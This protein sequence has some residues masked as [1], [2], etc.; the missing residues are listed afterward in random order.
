MFLLD[1]YGALDVLV[2]NFSVEWF[3]P[4]L[5]LLFRLIKTKTSRQLITGQTKWRPSSRCTYFPGLTMSHHRAI[6][7]KWTSSDFSWT[8]GG[9][10]TL[11]CTSSRISSGTFFSSLFISFL[12][13]CLLIFLFFFFLLSEVGEKCLILWRILLSMRLVNPSCT[14][15][16]CASVN[17][18]TTPT[19][20]NTL[21]K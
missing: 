5:S 1:F 13:L 10:Q 17:C 21:R 16:A 9:M 15:P 8:A 3:I 6:C 18:W 7:S 4:N 14:K 2:P 11:T 19:S 20:R 12:F